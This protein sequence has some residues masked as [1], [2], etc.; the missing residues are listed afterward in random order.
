ME[1]GV[2]GVLYQL[3]VS[4]VGEETSLESDFATIRLR[5]TEEQIALGK[6]QRK[7]PAMFSIVPLV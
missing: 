5:P 1:T 4:P 3:A 6:A 2:L 7:H